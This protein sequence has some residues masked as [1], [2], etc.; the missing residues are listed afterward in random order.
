MYKNER[1][2]R[3]QMDHPNM[4]SDASSL[5]ADL[6]SETAGDWLIVGRV[7]D[8]LGR[9]SSVS[10][11]GRTW[12][13]VVRD[14][15]ATLDRPVSIG[16]L[17]KI[18]RSFP[19]L[20]DGVR[21]LG[22]D[23]AAMKRAKIS[24]IEAAERLHAL[25]AEAGLDALRRCIAPG[26][27]ATLADVRAM[28]DAHLEIH[29]E[30]RSPKQIGWARRRAGPAVASGSSRSSDPGGVAGGGIQ[31][32]LDQLA[33][34]VAGLEAA[35][36]AKDARIAALREALHAKTVDYDETRARERAL[37]MHLRSARATLRE[38]GL[39]K[40]GRDA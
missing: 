24:S 12:H 8:D 34:H 9:L 10:T 28:L 7:L 35:S 4:S 19:F 16:H 29:P 11:D 13:E 18:G 31:D 38:A 23:D 30:Q 32:L 21:H 1:S 25:D 5:L 14:T 37:D 20:Q 39:I 26:Q 22:L 36:R 6:T 17:H 2:A 15:L 40:G 33:R 3:N 27:A